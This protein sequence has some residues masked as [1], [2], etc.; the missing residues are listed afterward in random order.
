MKNLLLAQSNLRK[1]K[2]LSICIT[3]LILISSMFICI[4]GLLVFD[5]QQNSYKVAKS[6]DTTQVEL[7]SYSYDYNTINEDYIKSI[8]P[9]TVDDYIYY[10]HL[11]TQTSIEF[12][13]GEVYTNINIINSSALKRRLSKIEIIEE[14]K[15]IKENYI[16]LPYHIHTGG[17]INIGDT[18]KL[19]LPD[20]TYSFKV[21]GFINTIYAGS[22]TMNLYEMM[23]S[24]NDYKIIEK[25]NSNINAFTIYINYKNTVKDIN[26]ETRKIV[27]K[28]FID[29]RIETSSYDL[30]ITLN[31]RTFLS[32]IFFV[33]FLLTSFIVIGITMLMI[34][35]NISNY[36]RENI[37]S[38]GILKA[39]GYTTKDIKIS[40]LLQFS[41]LTIIGL[42]IG[43]IIGYLFM[44]LIT[45]MLI[46]QS[47]IP[48]SVKFNLISTL[49]PIII[50]PIFIISI[51]LF[52]IRKIKKIEPII[53]LRDGIETHNFKKNHLPLNKTFLSINSSLA[54]KNIFKSIRQNITTFIIIIFLSFLMVITMTM[55]QNFSRE[56]KLSLLTFEIADGVISIDKDIKNEFEK[57]L[58]NNKD[59][60]KYEYLTNYEIQDIDYIQFATYIMDNPK[61][62]NNI[63][64]CYKG[65]HPKYDNE[66]AI[67]GKY[68]KEKKLDIGDKIEFYVGENK[69][70]YLITGLIQTANNNGHES[71]LTTKGA[72]HIIDV[73][74]LN[75]MYYFDSKIKTSKI[76]EYYENKYKDKILATIDFSDLLKSQMDTFINVAN[77]MIIIMSIISTT[78][79]LL[80]LYLLMKT[81]IYNR[82]YEYGILKALGYRSKDL[83]IQNVLSFMP[84]IIIASVIGTTIS[85]YITNPYIGL[86]MRSFGIMKCTMNIP[87]DLTI[88]TAIF[89]ISISLIGTILMSLRI[90][91]I[92]PKNLLTNE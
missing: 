36:I 71:V 1:N 35:N 66:I 7:I 37:K 6:L 20:K 64:N 77:L 24:D 40:Q 22:Y 33:S 74:N 55:Y 67:S 3:L 75:H 26:K 15:T 49:I 53:A 72:N 61:L 46:A 28:I 89:I 54:I 19:K 43:I 27:N 39:I 79:I 63:D 45:K 16:Y 23:I 88:I 56:P 69:Y 2:G 30:D 57:D 68:A 87:I 78:I 31:S 90:R 42:L 41:I 38:I 4:S 48:Y 47:G 76:I 62:L 13:D 29:K 21:K 80:I 83:I 58:K 32:M 17:G 86:T 84:T 70:S 11:N 85:Y 34:F 44:P 91:K 52:T 12:N 10:E 65:R 14:D 5:Y 73:D 59:I 18:Y 50:I 25:N 51:V 60:K 9:K 8:I 92:E 81:L 82:R